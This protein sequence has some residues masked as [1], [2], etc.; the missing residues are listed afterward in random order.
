MS[1]WRRA[2]VPVMKQR[3]SPG[4]LRVGVYLIATVPIRHKE[5]DTYTTHR[6]FIS[7]NIP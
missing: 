3:V 6:L 1:H 2:H 5:R 7:E 4:I